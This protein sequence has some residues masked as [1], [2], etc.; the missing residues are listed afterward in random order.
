MV[1]GQKMAKSTG[2]FFTLRDL[3]EKGWT[4]REVRYA[5]MS[6][7]YRLPLNFTF[8][9]LEAARKSLRRIDEW[10]R[11][12]ESLATTV[13]DD[14]QWPALEQ[15]QAA[16]DY[17]LNISAALGHL[18]VLIYETNVRMDAV[19]LGNGE[20]TRLLQVWETMNRVL[21]IVNPT[22][23]IPAGVASLVKERD[24]A[25]IAKNWPESDRLRDEIIAQGWA[26]K[27]TKEGTKITK[28]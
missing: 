4:G 9:G 12:L 22:D 26:V 27:D 19:D 18:F 23:E 24:T 7:N 13:A 25:R 11:R 5:V 6:V 15:F 10:V 2:N 1:E 17:D 20:A 8:E 21:G 16:M 3:L 28:N 14:S